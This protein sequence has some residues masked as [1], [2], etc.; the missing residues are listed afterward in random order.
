MCTHRAHTIVHEIIPYGAGAM[1]RERRY[2]LSSL[3]AADP[4]LFLS[5]ATNC[6][7]AFSGCL[8]TSA[9]TPPATKHHYHSSAI[10]K[11]YRHFD[12]WFWSFFLAFLLFRNLCLSTVFFFKFKTN[13][14]YDSTV[15]I[16]QHPYRR[17][18]YIYFYNYTYI[19]GKY[20]HFNDIYLFLKRPIMIWTTYQSYKWLV[21][22]LKL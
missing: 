4:W 14:V 10:V 9:P 21:I 16:K 22:S 6:V 17:R 15:W 2:K 18:I 20:L 12:F 7:S 11:L 13:S 19:L 3:W 5:W 8:H 1:L